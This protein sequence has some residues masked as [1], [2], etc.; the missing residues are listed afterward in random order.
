MF[1]EAIKATATTL[2]TLSLVSCGGKSQSALEAENLLET[3]RGAFEAGD[4]HRAFMLI[5]SLQNNYKAE[6]GVQRLALNLRPKVMEAAIIKEISSTDS[7][8]TSY[9]AEHDRLESKMKK[10][11]DQKL[12]EPYYVAVSGYDPSFMNGTGVQPRVDEVGQFFLISSVTGRPLKH[13]SITLKSNAGQVS[14]PAVAYDGELN[15][16]INGSELVTYMPEQGDTLGQFVYDNPAV[17]VTVVFNGA[18]GKSFSRRLTSAESQ[19]IA[20]AY[21]F[22]KSIICSRDLAV[23]RQKLERQLQVARDQIARTTPE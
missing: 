20:D 6:T 11:S 14:T 4:T 10:I 21:R 23:K 19:G 7:L 8:M 17:E 15:Y 12:V 3:A 5:D 13:E 16:R 22:S 9:A 2:I 1:K 18:G